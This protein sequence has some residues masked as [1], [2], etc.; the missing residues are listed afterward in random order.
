MVNLLA[1]LR[2]YIGFAPEQASHLEKGVSTV[3][4][5]ISILGVML[6]S[7]AQLGLSGSVSIISSM[8]SSAVLLFAVPHGPLSQPWSV[9]GG[10][11]VS[12]LVGVACVKLIH[13]PMLAA[14]LAVGLAIGAMHYLRCIHPPGGAT[15]LA[16]V[17][18]GD[19][20]HKLGFEFVLTPVLLNAITILFVA[21]LFN[22]PFPWRRYPVALAQRKAPDTQH[23]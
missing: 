14:A 23:N 17:I 3:G 12:A 5:I 13:Q 15:A 18:G 8:G 20:V 10:H 16:V 11:L 19:S 1:A 4:G 2:R 6:I 21:V 22:L 9:F 7:Q